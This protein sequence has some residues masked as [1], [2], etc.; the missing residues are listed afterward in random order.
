[1]NAIIFRLWLEA[2]KA[3]LEHSRTIGIIYTKE[4]AEDQLALINE[5]YDLFNLEAINVEDFEYHK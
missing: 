2:K 4:S 3:H 1:M 5:I